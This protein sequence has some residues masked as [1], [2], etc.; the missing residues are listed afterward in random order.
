MEALVS[1]TVDN[2]ILSARVPLASTLRQFLAAAGGPSEEAFLT[3]GSRPLSP[4]LELAHRWRDA[5]L[6][7]SVP[8]EMLVETP[9][10]VASDLMVLVGHDAP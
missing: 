2:R 4:D 1:M 6:S 9:A 3:D 5:S 10:L 7:S 8:G